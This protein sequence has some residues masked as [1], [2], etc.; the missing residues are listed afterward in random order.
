MP[1]DVGTQ[2]VV[3]FKKYKF[4]ITFADLFEVLHSHIMALVH[5]EVAV[6]G[7]L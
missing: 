4:I 2:F 6:H 3:L 1:C 5:V 7:H